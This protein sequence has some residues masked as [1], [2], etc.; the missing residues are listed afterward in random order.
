MEERTQVKLYV[1]GRV[2]IGIGIVYLALIHAATYFFKQDLHAYW[3]AALVPLLVAGYFGMAEERRFKAKWSE[4]APLACLLAGI[5]LVGFM[6][7]SLWL[8]RE[9]RHGH[10][11]PSLIPALK[12]RQFSILVFGLYAMLY[13]RYTVII[14]GIRSSNPPPPGSGA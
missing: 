4:E 11:N 9:Y 7:L 3:Q 14:N 12:S 8:S 6:G 10:G 1:L 2:M 5:G 13:C